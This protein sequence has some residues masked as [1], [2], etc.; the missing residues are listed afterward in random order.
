MNEVRRPSLRPD[1][2][3]RMPDAFSDP[4]AWEAFLCAETPESLVR[5]WLAL[6]V[7]MVPGVT[8]AAVF[9]ETARGQGFAPAAAWPD[10]RAADIVRP[11]AE[12]SL[13][14]RAAHLARDETTGLAA[15][16]YPVDAGQGPRLGIGLTLAGVPGGGLARVWRQLH[17]A[18]G[19]M[20][21]LSAER[22]GAERRA[23]AARAAFA[24]DTLAVA[25]EHEKLEPCALAVV[26]ALHARF[27]CAHVSLGLL[28]GE[29]RHARLRLVAMSRTASVRRRARLVADLENAMGEAVD[30]GGP[31]LTPAPE[32]TG[33]ARIDVAQRA[34]LEQAGMG[35][36]LTV[37]LVGSS[38]PVGALSFE[39]RE[40][41][42]FA[43]ADAE[44]A[45]ALGYMLGGLLALKQ[46]QRRW[47][48]GRIADAI[49]DAVRAV[50]GPRRASWKLVAVVVAAVLLAVTLI[51]TDLRVSATAVLEGATQRTAAAP[52]DGFVIAAPARAGDVVE[53]GQ[54]LAQLD[55]G[56]LR[57]EAL[58]WRSEHARLV[59]ERRV[60]MSRL[61]RAEVGLLIARIE[62]AAAQLALAE[63]RLARS[64]IAAPIAGVVIAGDLTQ[65][66]GGPVRQGEP[67]FEVAPLDDYR[68]AI[69][70]DERD[71][72]LVAPGQSGAMLLAGRTEA[73]VPVTLTAVTSVAEVVD[74]RNLFRVEARVDDPLIGV[75]PGMEGVAKIAV[76]RASLLRAWTRTLVHWL[77]VTAWEWRP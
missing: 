59:A 18:S 55:D 32:G 8:A 24:L 12:A 47:V 14:T 52:F 11:A 44:T 68:V 25:N 21:A 9:A 35:A 64:V 5:A 27:A 3:D 50:F 72:S 19:W 73:R 58:R 23:F 45:E 43:A 51:P 20:R 30:Q 69:R 31:V 7:R 29:G 53:A 2:A 75:R 48:S 70:V 42:P 63:A 16:G 41:T 46:R 67:L 57:L 66:I 49:G 71:L 26:N 33:P 36:A 28:R 62:Q 65:R 37:P 10:D 56:D 1:G 60:A 61:D 38:G 17:W 54:M 4:A 6:V 76:G 13:S 22:E 74:G 34:Y 40:A 15:L 39:R 77:T